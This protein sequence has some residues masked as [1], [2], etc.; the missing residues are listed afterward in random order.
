MQQ[1]KMDI[2]EPRRKAVQQ[3]GALQEEREARLEHDRALARQTLPPVR[4]ASR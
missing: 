4:K 3:L 2:S 1:M